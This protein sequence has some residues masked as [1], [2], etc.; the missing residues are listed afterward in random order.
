VLAHE[1]SH[2]IDMSTAPP[3]KRTEFRGMR[4]GIG[5]ERA[6][7][8]I[9]EELYGVYRDL[10]NPRAKNWGPT[11]EGY[12]RHEVAKE[13]WAEAIRAY[14]ADPNYLKSVAPKTA[15]A[16]R[17]A[18]NEN[19]ELRH[20]IQFNVGGVPGGFA[21]GATSAATADTRSRE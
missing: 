19:D 7:E 3:V 1:L 14:M 4:W 9:E 15:A 21:S 10:N 5:A 13:L 12:A 8:N 11:D 17:A 20:I 6:D 2:H 18:V 16:I